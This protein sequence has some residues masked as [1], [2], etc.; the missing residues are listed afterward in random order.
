M[1]V[2]PTAFA[3]LLEKNND[4][5][6]EAERDVIQGAELKAIFELESMYD[7]FY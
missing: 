6:V 2:E 3:P 1:H 7:R 5:R 4:F